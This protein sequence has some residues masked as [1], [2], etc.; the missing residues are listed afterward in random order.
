MSNF[1][2]LSQTIKN[3]AKISTRKLIDSPRKQVLKAKPQPILRK[4]SKVFL[5]RITMSRAELFPEKNVQ[6]NRMVT[7]LDTSELTQKGKERKSNLKKLKSQLIRNN[8]PNYQLK[9]SNSEKNL[10]IQNIRNIGNLDKT[11][12]EKKKKKKKR[13]KRE[14]RE[15]RKEEK[16]ERTKEK[17]DRGEH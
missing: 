7:L 9:K 17:E 3:K 14:K 5:P 10:S 11:N 16:K 12:D 6:D 15:R 4:Q 1:V 2:H 13:K 8:G